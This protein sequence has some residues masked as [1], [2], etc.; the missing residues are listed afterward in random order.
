MPGCSA[1]PD[2][3]AGPPEPARLRCGAGCLCASVPGSSGTRGHGPGSRQTAD[4]VLIAAVNICVPPGYTRVSSLRALAES[5]AEAPA[6]LW[7]GGLPR[8]QAGRLAGRC[9][10]SQ[11]PGA[12]SS[13]PRLRHPAR[14]AG[15]SPPRSADTC[16]PRAATP[17]T[18]ASPAQTR[19]ADA[20]PSLT[21]VHS[22]LQTAES[23]MPSRG[24]T[25]PPPLCLLYPPP[26]CPSP[27]LARADPDIR[28]QDVPPPPGRPPGLIEHP[29]QNVKE[30]MLGGAMPRSPEWGQ[31][32][33]RG[34]ERWF[35]RDLVQ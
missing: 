5:E 30:P 35:T 22:Q 20:V 26:G 23:S 28:A 10:L 27:C 12:V 15:A 24:A 34:R 21:S 18:G 7:G 29:A 6:Q 8:R 33:C 32:E 3:P 16:T 17:T 4:A 14:P 11:A 1:S 13:C 31:G 19:P 2:A 25:L 9:R